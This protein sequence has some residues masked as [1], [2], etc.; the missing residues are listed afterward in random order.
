MQRSRRGPWVFSS[1]VSHRPDLA[2]GV[3]RHGASYTGVTSAVTYLM[4]LTICILPAFVV[5]FEKST[6]YLEAAM[7][8]RA[9]VAGLVGIF[10][11]LGHRWF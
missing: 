1:S 10:V 11:L 8:T 3:D 9:A 7:I 5:A 2:V 4:A 6:C